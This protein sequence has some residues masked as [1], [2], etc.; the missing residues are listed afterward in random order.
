MTPAEVDAVGVIGAGAVGHT[1]ATT[2]V[3][4]ALPGRLLIAS[5][6]LLIVS[7]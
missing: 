1:V 7:E 5:R 4:S 3:A 6:A 2:L